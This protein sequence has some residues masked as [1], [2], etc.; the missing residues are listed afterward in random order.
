[1]RNTI[2][3]L[4]VSLLTLHLSCVS[5]FL[6]RSGLTQSSIRE[7]SGEATYPQGLNLPK[8][9]N[10]TSRTPL[11]FAILASSTIL[12]FSTLILCYIRPILQLVLFSAGICRFA[13]VTVEAGGRLSSTNH[14]DRSKSTW[15]GVFGGLEHITGVSTIV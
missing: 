11:S 12:S 4:F 10:L 9:S 6:H 15:G 3:E 8:T 2:A 13:I 7:K 5:P 14:H 1:M